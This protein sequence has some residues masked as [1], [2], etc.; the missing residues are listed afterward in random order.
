MVVEYI[1][2]EGNTVDDF[3]TNRVFSFASTT[4]IQFLSR[5]DL[6]AQQKKLLQIDKQGI[7][8]LKIRNYQNEKF[9]NK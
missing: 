8:N 5:T 7:P 2:K 9:N 1:F 3:L 4:H 6:P